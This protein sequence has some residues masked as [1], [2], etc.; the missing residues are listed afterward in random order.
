MGKNKNE[1]KAEPINKID[2]VKNEEAVVEDVNTANLDE[3]F[4]EEN[5]NKETVAEEV[6]SDAEKKEDDGDT[7]EAKKRELKEAKLAQKEAKRNVKELERNTK[8]ATK[9]RDTQIII[10]IVIAVIVLAFGIFGFYFYK[11]NMESV[12]TF[13]GGKVSR[14]DYE[15]YYKT[16]A[17]MLEYYGYPASIIPEQIAN[18]AALDA[19]IVEMAKKDNV[20]IT[21]EN[22][23]SIDEVFNDQDQLKQ[24]SQ[25]GIDIGRMKKLYY[26]DYL[27]TAYIEKISKEATD[28]EIAT[29]IKSVS[30]E[31]VDMNQY[32]TSHILF[33]TTDS[34]NQPL[35]DAKKAEAKQKA[36][37][38]LARVKNGEDFATVAKELSEDTGTKENGGKYTCYSDG[39]TLEEYI[40]AAKSLKDGE[41]YATVVETSAGYHI[42]KLDSKVEN[43]RLQNDTERQEYADQKINKYG[44]ERN[45]KIDMETVNKIVESITGKKP[46]DD[47]NNTDN[48]ENNTE[49][50]ENNTET[51]E[52]NDTSN[53][54]EQQ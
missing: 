2:E 11:A 42:I 28:E 29:Y 54:G 17:S 13:D 26:N 30:G 19:I 16:F 39:N 15:V 46:T 36:E 34:S 8:K 40:N 27:I 5:D 4:E 41:I 31:D 32:N 22:Q 12:A 43:G 47:T 3:F 6:S 51:P 10:G 18:K 48:T 25:Q 21:A 9:N 37:A 50:N 49:N 14:A 44:E 38:A 52:N 53:N 33:K 23:K 45:L 20:Q 7:L 24:F 35:D 1:K